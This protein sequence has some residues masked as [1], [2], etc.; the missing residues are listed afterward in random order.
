ME[1]S[2]ESIARLRQSIRDQVDSEFGWLRLLR[3]DARFAGEVDNDPSRWTFWRMRPYPSHPAIGCGH[4][5]GFAF[6]HQYANF[7]GTGETITLLARRDQW[8]R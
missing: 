6:I 2:S 7:A 1:D 8:R 3:A 5:D 4:V